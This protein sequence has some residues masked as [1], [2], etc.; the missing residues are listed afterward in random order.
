MVRRG[1]EPPASRL[2]WSLNNNDYQPSALAR[3][4]NRTIGV[5]TL[6]WDGYKI[7]PPEINITKWRVSFRE[8][9]GLLFLELEELPP[10]ELAAGFLDVRGRQF[11]FFAN[12]GHARLPVAKLE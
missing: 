11:G 8:R 5:P 7:A 9:V 12:L 3:L 10:L 1:F 2:C 6:P 4:C